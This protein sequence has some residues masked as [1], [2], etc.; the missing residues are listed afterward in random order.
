[1]R[2]ARHGGVAARDVRRGA[3]PAPRGG[4]VGGVVPRGTRHGGAGAVGKI[5]ERNGASDDGRAQWRE[6]ERGEGPPRLTMNG[7]ERATTGE[8]KGL[9]RSGARG[10]RD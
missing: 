4:L 3:L 1:S 9:S 2:A 8:R 6:P 7:M 5:G 10:P